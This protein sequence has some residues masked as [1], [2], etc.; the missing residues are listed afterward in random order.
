MSK[1]SAAA[2]MA[3]AQTV[4][5]RCD[6]EMGAKFLERAVQAEPSNMAPVDMLAGV[7]L[8][9]G[10]VQGA[11]GLLERS[12]T[13]DP[14]G[15]YEK[16]LQYGQIS[17]G[18]QA[19]ESYGRGI[20]L[21]AK[22][23]AHMEAQMD[24]ST[25][26][27]LGRELASAYCSCVEIYMTDLCFA[28]DAE[29]KCQEFC[30]LALQADPLGVEPLQTL[31]NF[32]ICQNKPA[33]AAK[34]MKKAMKLLS[35]CTAETM[36]SYHL[37]CAGAKMLIELKQPKM[38]LQLLTRLLAEDDEQIEVWYIAGVAAHHTG[39]VELATEYLTKARTMLLKVREGMTPAQAEQEVAPMLAT[40]N[41]ELATVEAA[42]A[43]AGAAAAAGAGGGDGDAMED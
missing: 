27:M 15:G 22:A 16:Y 11:K 40:V 7:W 43:G 28:A 5:E 26:A 42:G 19:V 4:L 20:T 9:M 17:T 36:P 12:I 25:G 8:E 41:A 37:R 29:A 30:E 24:F 33:Q 10:N 14:N 1:H 3:Q 23:K 2:L 35:K 39:D 38:G 32:R 13:A 21:L 6:L 18:A 34:A 31:A